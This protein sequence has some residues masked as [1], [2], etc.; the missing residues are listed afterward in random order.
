M[1]LASSTA[2]TLRQELL[3][4][5]DTPMVAEQL[6]AAVP[7][8]VFC[9]KNRKGQYISANPAFAERLGLRSVSQIIGKTASD[10]FPSHLA[11]NY[12][13]QDEF[14][15]SQ[16]KAINDRLELVFNRDRSLGWYLARKVP[17]WNK[18]HEVVGL[19][20]ISR[21][22]LTPGDKDLQFS[23]LAKVIEY[24]HSNYASD[25]NLSHL[26]KIANLSSPQLE[27]RMRKIF[28]L[29]PSQFIRKT[30]IEAASQMLTETHKS[31]VEIALDCG[32]S[33]QSSF[34]RQFRSTVG[35]TPGAYRTSYCDE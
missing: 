24:I 22:L 18:N 30:R 6:F 3:D 32:Y 31:I 15:F 33:D 21:D 13:N 27:R 25:I 10:I 16:G 14:V 35:M 29:T 2:K 28:K 9:M 7:D 4:Q 23:G 17:L 5:L 26:A 19:A 20:S 1:P 34:T 8:I 12:L 11:N